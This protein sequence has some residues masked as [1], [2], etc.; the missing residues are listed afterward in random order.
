MIFFPKRFLS[1]GFKILFAYVQAAYNVQAAYRSWLAVGGG[2]EQVGGQLGEACRA[3]G[4]GAGRG[5]CA[6]Q[7]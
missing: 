1:W 5:R 7:F 3:R 4:G 2:A 6:G